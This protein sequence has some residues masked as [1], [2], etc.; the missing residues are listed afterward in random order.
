MATTVF[1]S[2]LPDIEPAT[3]PAAVLDSGACPWCTDY[4]GD[5]PRRHASAA[6]PDKYDELD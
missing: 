4:D 3:D 1:P 2:I 5:S 6:H